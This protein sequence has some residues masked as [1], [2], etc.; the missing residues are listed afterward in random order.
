[1][2][3]TVVILVLLALPHT[4]VGAEPHVTIAAEP[5]K[6]AR[7]KKIPERQTSTEHTPP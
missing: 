1:V 6:N 5:Q 3:R 7:S 2:K 4:S